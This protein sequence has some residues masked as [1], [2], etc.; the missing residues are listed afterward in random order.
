M[1]SRAMHIAVYAKYSSYYF[2]MSL[3]FTD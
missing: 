1:S 2:N 3:V